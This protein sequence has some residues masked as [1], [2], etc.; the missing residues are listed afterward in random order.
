MR[1]RTLK[2]TKILAVALT[3]AGCAEGPT[4][5]KTSAEPIRADPPVVSTAAPVEVQA[6]VTAVPQP[7]PPEDARPGAGRRMSED[8][9]LLALA[10]DLA[11]DGKEKALAQVPR[12]RPLCD[13]DGY[14]LV[15]NVMR[16]G[17]SYQPSAFC[18]VVR[19]RAKK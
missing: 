14:P 8:P 18:A 12:Y 4:A 2:T 9:A 19:E 6:A 1:T 15:G 13:A 5:A 10:S 16:K 3:A 17:A 11:N 7:A